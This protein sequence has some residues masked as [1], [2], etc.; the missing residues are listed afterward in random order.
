MNTPLSGP[1][2]RGAPVSPQHV[3]HRHFRTADLSF[4]ATVRPHELSGKTLCNKVLWRQPK[5][6]GSADNAG[7][8]VQ[9]DFGGKV[10]DSLSASCI[11]CSDGA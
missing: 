8:A 7:R 2:L 11:P 4:R 9:E 1:G 10:G 5:L 6:K 3:E